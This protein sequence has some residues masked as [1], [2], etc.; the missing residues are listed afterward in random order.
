VKQT[1]KK[2]GV[3]VVVD[4]P[5]ATPTHSADATGY[6]IADIKQIESRHRRHYTT[7]GK[8][9]LYALFLDWNFA[10]DEGSDRILGQAYQ[11]ESVVIF[12]NS[13]KTA[14]QQAAHP[15]NP[16]SAV[17]MH[18]FGHL[19]GLVGVNDQASPHADLAH[20]S[21]TNSKC[22]MNHAAE[23]SAQ[24]MSFA[25]DQIPLLDDDCE[26]DLKALKN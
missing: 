23:S 8:L 21:C 19:M 7:K 26:N 16:E 14:T 24:I 18:E 12:M 13:L 5:I 20:H 3:Q 17:L 1:G 9:A 25:G 2:R 11:N 22:L 15:A 10:G 4:P 6:S